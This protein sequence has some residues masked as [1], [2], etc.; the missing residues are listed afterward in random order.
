MLEISSSSLSLS[1]T[2]DV[3]SARDFGQGGKGHSEDK[4]Q[5][6]RTRRE[7]DG[8][9]STDIE[10]KAKKSQERLSFYCLLT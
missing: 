9:H 4:L 1:E 7:I 2:C 8:K 10:G 6:H 3:G 5:R